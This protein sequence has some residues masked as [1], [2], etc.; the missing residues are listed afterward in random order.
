M[1][2]IN[3]KSLCN[4]YKKVIVFRTKNTVNHVLGS[5][6]VPSSMQ[7]RDVI[8][9]ILYSSGSFRFLPVSRTGIF[10][11]RYKNVLLNINNINQSVFVFFVND[12]KLCQ[13][14]SICSFPLTVIKFL[15]IFMFIEVLIEKLFQSFSARTGL[16]PMHDAYVARRVVN[17]LLDQVFVCQVPILCMNLQHNILMSATKANRVSHFWA[18]HNTS[19]GL[20]A[21]KFE[22]PTF[23]F[24]CLSLKEVNNSSRL[25]KHLQ[26]AKFFSCTPLFRLTYSFF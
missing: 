11:F 9:S 20:K 22:N 19:F 21:Q 3:T 12:C 2:E 15:T 14:F 6:L 26:V 1:F 5:H 23:I 4:W 13:Y 24:G 17:D 7:P 25:Q 18:S 16:A 8:Y 10:S